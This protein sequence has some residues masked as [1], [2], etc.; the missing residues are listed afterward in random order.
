MTLDRLHQELADVK[1]L[2]QQIAQEHL[3]ARRQQ[4]LCSAH[5]PATSLQQQ[6]CS[7]GNK[8]GGADEDAQTAAKSHTPPRP[9]T[10]VLL[11]LPRD[12]L[13]ST[14]SSDVSTSQLSLQP[15]QLAQHP[16]LLLGQGL[17]PS[18]SDAVMLQ[19]AVHA[20]HHTQVSGNSTGAKRQVCA[21]CHQPGGK[22]GSSIHLP[23]LL[24]QISSSVLG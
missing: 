7:C 21:P 2:L 3:I 12:E 20:A 22:G 9:K 17:K 16:L 4:P 23:L 8:D 24:W 6:G 15:Q 10:S 18:I 11:D 13:H 1:Q 14:D 19:R 5:E